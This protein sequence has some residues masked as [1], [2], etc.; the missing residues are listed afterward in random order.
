MGME[1]GQS[2]WAKRLIETSMNCADAGSRGCYAYISIGSNQS[3][4]THDRRRNNILANRGRPRLTTLLFDD[5]NTISF[6]M[7]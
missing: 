1:G 4:C 6:H 3:R 5:S 7:A 2:N